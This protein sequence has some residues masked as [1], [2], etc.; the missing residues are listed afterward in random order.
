MS[1]LLDVT[2]SSASD[3]DLDAGSHVTNGKLDDWETFSNL[4]EN[5]SGL[6]G[7]GWDTEELSGA[8]SERSSFISVNPDSVGDEF[9][10]DFPNPKELAA[11]MNDGP[12]ASNSTRTELYDSATTCHILPYHN[13]FNNFVDI[14]PK[15]LNAANKQRFTAVGQGYT[16]V[17]I[18]KLDEQGYKFSFG[19][20]KMTMHNQD[21]KTIGEVLKTDKGV[22]KV[23][24]NGDNSLYA[25]TEPITLM[26]FHHHMGHISPAVAKRLA[27]KGMATGLHADTSSG[28]MVF[29]KSCIYAK[30]THK[31]IV[32]E[33][34][35]E[36][37]KEFGNEI[38]TN[39]WGPAPVATL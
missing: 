4:G 28:E 22:Y 26:E 13:I 1:G 25:A 29:C 37:T 33:C 17:S 31:P 14:A 34:Q 5:H 21:G 36:Q 16:L 20:G 3:G 7:D 24:H 9:S 32:K 8:E 23:I 11:N 10:P 15:S 35:G 39:L 2:D 12:I 38:H 19:D 6:W 18:R 30:A 27:E